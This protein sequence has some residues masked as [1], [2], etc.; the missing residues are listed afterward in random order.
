MQ[1][2]T[3]PL[4]KHCSE[5]MVHFSHV[6]ADTASQQTRLWGNGRLKPCSHVNYTIEWC[7]HRHCLSTN[8]ALRQWCTAAMQAPTL[9]FYKHCPEVMVHRSHA[10]AHWWR[11][12]CKLT[13]SKLNST[14]SGINVEYINSIYTIAIIVILSALNCWK[15]FLHALNCELNC[16][17]EL[18]IG[19]MAKVHRLA[20]WYF[21]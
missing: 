10:S 8:T 18:I 20:K 21:V 6:S 19:N 2:P 9:P 5:V 4:N 3:L 16:G 13:L 11:M 17:N 1:P 7:K 15:F 14:R 12:Q